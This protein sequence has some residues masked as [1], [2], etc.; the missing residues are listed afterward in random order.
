VYKWFFYTSLIILQA[1]LVKACANVDKAIIEEGVVVE[2]NLSQEAKAL[3]NTYKITTEDSKILN[4]ASESFSLVEKNQ[5]IASE[6]QLI[7]RNKTEK[8]QD[9]I[10]NLDVLQP[11]NDEDNSSEITP[12]FYVNEIKN[13][14]YFIPLCKYV[15][16]FFKNENLNDD[17]VTTL[18]K[19]NNIDSLKFKP[20]GLFKL[21]YMYSKKF[22]EQ[23]LIQVALRSNCKVEKIEQI[24]I[25]ADEKKISANS[26]L[27]S[28]IKKCKI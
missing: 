5:K 28:I 27:Y 16:Y 2:K 25:I 19:G 9:L 4:Q 18:L 24:K 14:Q 8:I 7:K 21:Y 17:Q 11:D 15:R 10:E 22:S 23:V 6:F 12:E 3:E 26:L 13:S 20:A 1:G